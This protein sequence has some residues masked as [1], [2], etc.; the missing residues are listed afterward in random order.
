M[1]ARASVPDGGWGRG[2]GERGR[3][4]H[5]FDRHGLLLRL[6]ALIVL[7]HERR[8]TRVGRARRAPRELRHDGLC[9][10]VCGAAGAAGAPLRVHRRGLGCSTQ[11][12]QRGR[13]RRARAHCTRLVGPIPGLAG[14]LPRYKGLRRRLIPLACTCAAGSGATEAWVIREDWGGGFRPI[15]FFI[16]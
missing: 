4:P 15:L 1:C 14:P 9:H 16:I 12:S 2:C 7:L 3:P 11:R 5:L 8:A 6:H 13:R 10:V